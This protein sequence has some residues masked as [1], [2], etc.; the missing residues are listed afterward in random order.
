VIVFPLD[1]SEMNR[2]RATLKV[3]PTSHHPP[4]Y[5]LLTS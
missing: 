4:L 1:I 2:T 5:E 3:L